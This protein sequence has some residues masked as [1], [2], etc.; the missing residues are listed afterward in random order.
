M[1][2][3]AVIVVAD[4]RSLKRPF[5]F[6]CAVNTALCFFLLTM[7]A[8]GHRDL[9]QAGQV[10]LSLVGM[11][12]LMCHSLVTMTTLICHSLVTMTTLICHSLVAMTTLPCVSLS[13]VAMT[14]AVSRYPAQLVSHGS[15]VVLYLLESGC[16]LLSVLGVLGACWGKRWCLILFAAGMAA[17][18]QTIIVKTALSYRDIYESGVLR[19]ESKLLAMMPLSGPRRTN[20]T[21]LHSIQA[22]FQCCGLVEGYKDWGPAIPASCHCQSPGSCIRL[23]GVATLGAP[24]NQYVYQEACL[25]IYVSALKRGFSLAMGIK[26]GSGIFWVVLMLMSMKLMVQL[27]RKH[28]FLSLVQ[29]NR[30][31]AGAF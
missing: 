29:S 6:A 26:F 18:S 25:P 23:R 17:A 28:K 21:L 30:Y 7:T 1:Q 22:H 20:R 31:V 12:T 3:K 14:A 2:R 27:K 10:F 16:L 5:I 13:L 8:A 19:E 4:K 15:L 9:L 24:K 11:T